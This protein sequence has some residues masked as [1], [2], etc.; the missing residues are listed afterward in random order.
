METCY[1]VFRREVIQS[2]QIEENRFGFEPEVVAKIAQ[3]RLRVYETGIS[4]RGRT[5]A[6]GKKIGMKDAWRA[7]YCILKYNLHIVPLPV[8]FLFYTCIAGVAAIV[9]LLCFVLLLRI[10]FGL[11]PSVLAAFFIAAGVNYCLSVTLLFRHRVRWNTISE[12]LVYL[13]VVITV[14]IVDLGCT[15][16]FVA[17]GVNPPLAKILSTVIGLFLNF[18][19]RRFIVFPEKTNP[20]WKP[21]DPN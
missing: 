15:H 19:G 12:I 21:Q 17:L 10:G 14:S 1:K 3:M 20:D 11:T 13:A 16:G 5:Y 18:A 8:Q 4:Y 2:I 7:L 6:E 9:N